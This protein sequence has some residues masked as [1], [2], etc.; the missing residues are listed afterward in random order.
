MSK[1]SSIGERIKAVRLKAGLNQDAFAAA[2]GYSKRALVSWEAG[3]AEPPVAILGKLRRDFDVDPEWI[4]M[5]EDLTPRS[6][7]GPVD[8]ERL[9]R[10]AHDVDAICIDVGLKLNPERRT[11]LARIQY[12]ADTDA[13]PANRKQ[14]RGMLLTLSQRG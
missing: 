8:W 6:Y 5:G 1:S 14:L 7:Y 10:I 4:V 12:D 11:A 13:G 9:D 2:L 3:A